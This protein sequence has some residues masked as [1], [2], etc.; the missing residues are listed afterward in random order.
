MPYDFSLIAEPMFSAATVDRAAHLRGNTEALENGW[1]TALVM[2][3]DAK[4]KFRTEVVDGPDTASDRGTGHSAAD[5]PGRGRYMRL[6]FDPA[7][8]IAERPPH[9]AV[10]LGIAPSGRHI[11]ALQTDALGDGGVSDLR[12]CGEFLLPH[13]AALAAEAVA[14]LAWHR[15]NNAGKSP[16]AHL[17]R[18]QSGWAGR[19]PASQ[20][21][22]FPRTDPAVICL[23]HDGHRRMLLAR[24]SGW[25]QN[26]YSVLAGFVEAGESLE[27]CVI[28]EIFEEVGLD[29][30]N[31]RYLGS[32]PWP[33]PRSLMLG[34][35]ALAD[36]NQK[37][38]H[39]DGEISE[40][41]WLDVR[42]VE[43]LLSGE[44]THIVLPGRVSISRVMIES[45]VAAV[46]AEIEGGSGLSAQ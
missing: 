1:P 23:V 32:Q 7:F 29:V 21:E 46:N 5:D 44:D 42:E 26:F 9:L 38:D 13:D 17:A 33:F 24:N 11:W 10:F 34:F 14:L 27:N 39:K 4:G 22:E 43:R 3:V 25:T 18:T 35:H 8:D 41:I 31:P 30:T 20:F 6:T 12:S 2:R 16:E 45:W 40:S 28:R 36:P 15:I 19:D 37:I